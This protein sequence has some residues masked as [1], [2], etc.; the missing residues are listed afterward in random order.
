[1]GAKGKG[2]SCNVQKSKTA[3]RDDMPIKEE[4][5]S[6]HWTQHLQI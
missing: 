4:D 1:M 3:A 6:K 2:C 5:R